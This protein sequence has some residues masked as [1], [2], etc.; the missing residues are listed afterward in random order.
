MKRELVVMAMTSFKKMN[1]KS[2]LVV[3]LQADK[4]H[5]IFQVMEEEYFGGLNQKIFNR[6]TFFRLC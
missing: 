2:S 1:K 5:F 6:K 4:V 3:I